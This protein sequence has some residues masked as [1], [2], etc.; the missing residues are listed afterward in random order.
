MSKLPLLRK[1]VCLLNNILSF[2]KLQDAV[3][4][5]YLPTNLL[6]VFCL[7]LQQRANSIL[8]HLLDLLEQ[9]AKRLEIA[10]K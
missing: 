10:E 8:S 4:S 3:E 9:L 2:C 1:I 6:N 5:N 7:S